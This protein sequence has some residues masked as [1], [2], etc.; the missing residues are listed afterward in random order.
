MMSERKWKSIVPGKVA[1][2]RAVFA[3]SKGGSN[4]KGTCPI[5]FAERL[6]RYYQ[7][8][9]VVEKESGGIR[10]VARGACWEWCSC[11]L[12]Y[13]HYSA[14]VPDWW[15]NDLS[16]DENQLTAFPDALED[17]LSLGV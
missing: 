3:A 2:W 4:V 11:C 10:F 12:T 13:E 1:R 15:T 14:L 8:G 6:H 7:V 17:S 9:P 16:V 5:C